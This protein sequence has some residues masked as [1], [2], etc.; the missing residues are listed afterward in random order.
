MTPLTAWTLIPKRRRTKTTPEIK[1]MPHLDHVTPQESLDA[2]EPVFLYTDEQGTW[3][4]DKE[5]RREI[6]LPADGEKNGCAD[7]IIIQHRNPEAE[8]DPVQY[9]LDS[10]SQAIKPRFTKIWLGSRKSREITDPQ[11][12][13]QFGLLFCN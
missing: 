1:P 8:D 4:V 9:I 11:R 5:L 6:L 10:S 7:W 2:E 13:A 3:L 12:L